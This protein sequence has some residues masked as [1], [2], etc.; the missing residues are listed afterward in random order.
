MASMAAVALVFF[1]KHDRHHFIAK[2]NWKE[3]LNHC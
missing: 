1:L 2:I 3:R